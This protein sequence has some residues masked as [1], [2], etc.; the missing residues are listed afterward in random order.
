MQERRNL[1]EESCGGGAA[2]FVLGLSGGARLFLPGSHLASLLFSSENFSVRTWRPLR[3]KL[4][5]KAIS[6]PFNCPSPSVQPHPRQTECALSQPCTSK[7][8][9]ILI[10]SCWLH[11]PHSSHKPLVKLNLYF[12]LHEKLYRH[13]PAESELSERRMSRFGRD[14][15]AISITIRRSDSSLTM[16]V[17]KHV[18]RSIVGDYSTTGVASATGVCCIPSWYQLCQICDSGSG[19]FLDHNSSNC[20]PILKLWTMIFLIYCKDV[21]TKWILILMLFFQTFRDIYLPRSG[22]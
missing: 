21:D 22:I 6:C 15:G 19:N 12:E 11:W 1:F 10:A 18:I 7:S 20:N 3:P 14:S 9:L 8:L 5:W 16:R 4:G 2:Q 17:D 13:A